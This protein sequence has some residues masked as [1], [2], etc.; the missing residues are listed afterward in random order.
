MTNDE[1]NAEVV[2][3]RLLLEER[4]G[5]IT[6]LIRQI[7]NSIPEISKDLEYYVRKVFGED[8]VN[9]LYN[10]FRPKERS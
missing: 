1:L 10:N 4:N 6:D 2:R 5:M 8:G 7:A 9:T 3:L